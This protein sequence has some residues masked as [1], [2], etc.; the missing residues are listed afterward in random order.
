MK[1][2]EKGKCVDGPQRQIH[3]ENISFAVNFPRI[4]F[5]EK[6]HHDECIEN[7]GKMLGWRRKKWGTNAR[8]NAQQC[9]ALEQKEHEQSE[10][11]NCMAT[12]VFTKQ[13]KY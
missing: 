2:A 5:I 11:V 12:N 10:L 8:I 6:G 3:F 9:G 7:N 13:I 4:D 1:D